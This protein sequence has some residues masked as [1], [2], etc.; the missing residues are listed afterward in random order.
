MPPHLPGELKR[1]RFLT[2]LAQNP[3]TASI[4]N[5]ALNAIL[6]FY[7]EAMEVQLKNIQALRARRPSQLRRA[8]NHEDTLLL[9]KTVQAGGD[10]ATSLVVRL[11][12]GCGLRVPLRS[13]GLLQS[14]WLHPLPHRHETLSQVASENLHT[15]NGLSPDTY[16]LSKLPRLNLIAT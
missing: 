6:F 5:Q 14:P 10:F 7:K 8:P 13:Q 9:I 1:E 11:L 12:Y 3:V 15:R 16:D 4:R 2:A